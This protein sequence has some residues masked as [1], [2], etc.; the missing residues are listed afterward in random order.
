MLK[1]REVENSAPKSIS[2]P[3]KTGDLTTDKNRT[4]RSSRTSK[5]GANNF[6]IPFILPLAA[7]LVLS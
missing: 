2:Q 6:H 5:T 4:I 3:P 7:I 1:P